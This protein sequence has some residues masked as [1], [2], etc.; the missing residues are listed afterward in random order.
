MSHLDHVVRLKE[1]LSTLNV[2]CPFE[3]RKLIDN[4][5]IDA[6]VAAHFNCRKNFIVCDKENEAMRCQIDKWNSVSPID[7]EGIYH[8]YRSFINLMFSTLCTKGRGFIKAVIINEGT[9]SACNLE[10]V[11]EYQDLVAYLFQEVKNK[12]E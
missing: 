10:E 3:Q 4:A 8:S 7:H 5:Y 6:L 1:K 12:H 2:T 9:E 11:Q